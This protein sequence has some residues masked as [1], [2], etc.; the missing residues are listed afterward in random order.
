MDKISK[1]LKKLRAEER[2]ELK[3]I[4]LKFKSGKFD[5]FDIKKLKSK[6]NIF[7]IRKGKFR[8]IF[9]KN[10]S[11]VIILAVEKRGDNTYNL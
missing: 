9:I 2:T 1:A 11:S 5:N 3:K 10:D 4:L 8:I 6:N 7:R